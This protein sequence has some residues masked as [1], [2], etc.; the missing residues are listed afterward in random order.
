[1]RYYSSN[2]SAK[3]LPVIFHIHISNEYLF[4]VLKWSMGV[5]AN[6]G[7]IW[8]ELFNCKLKMRLSL[9]FSFLWYPLRF[10]VGNVSIY[11]QQMWQ[12]LPIFA[13][14]GLQ[15]SEINTNAGL[16]CGA[17]WQRWQWWLVCWAAH[18]GP[19]YISQI[20]RSNSCTPPQHIYRP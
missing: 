11:C 18:S 9:E 10:T 12:L 7:I 17:K 15:H 20:T 16:L 13:A 6:V 3:M 19:A 14:A 1:M 4:P 2:K 8:H 5:E